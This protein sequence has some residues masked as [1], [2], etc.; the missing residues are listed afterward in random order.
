MQTSVQ[1]ALNSIENLL[2]EQ[3]LYYSKSENTYFMGLHGGMGNFELFQLPNAMTGL[4]VSK[5]LMPESISAAVTGVLK[6]DTQMTGDTKGRTV[7]I[8]NVLSAELYG[9]LHDQSLASAML[10]AAKHHQKQ[11]RKASD[12][13]YLNHLVEVLQILVHFEPESD[14]S[15]RVAAILH[16]VV[17]D[18]SV[19]IESVKFLFGTEV[20]SIVSEL[21]CELATDSKD[22]KAQ[23]LRQISIASVKAKVIKLA[24]VISNI[25]LLPQDWSPE[26]K[27][28]YTGWCKK[29]ASACA[30]ASI[31]SFERFNFLIGNSHLESFAGKKKP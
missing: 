6:L 5:E 7:Q 26:R 14:E 16:D 9:K 24:D 27:L 17:E 31:R 8:S 20:A 15:T 23:L 13:P 25:S 1:Q 28:A 10:F 18:T 21:T 29:V 4:F 12:E 3:T 22:K 30:A 11:K 2:K 19:T